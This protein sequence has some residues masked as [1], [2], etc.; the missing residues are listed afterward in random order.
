MKIL[1]VKDKQSGLVT[2]EP[3]DGDLTLEQANLRF[4]AGSGKEAVMISEE[5][6]SPVQLTPEFLEKVARDANTAL[7][8]AS[9][10]I[11]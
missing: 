6:Y 1:F 11:F 10:S 7:A 4:R 9:L 3:C 8:C 5:N 2:V